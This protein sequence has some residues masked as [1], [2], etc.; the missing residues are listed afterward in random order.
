MSRFR[1]K[2]QK[3][4]ETEF[5]MSYFVPLFQKPTKKSWQHEEDQNLLLLIN[6]HGNAWK[7]IA[8]HMDGRTAKQC[9]ER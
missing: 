4:N 7:Q 6:L 2:N 3:Y 9:R 5:G 8:E 1:E